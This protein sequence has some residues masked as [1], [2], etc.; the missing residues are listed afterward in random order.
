MPT[1]G[2]GLGEMPGVPED[3][4]QNHQKGRGKGDWKQRP[5]VQPRSEPRSGLVG[6]GGI[7]SS[8]GAMRRDELGRGGHPQE[9]HRGTEAV[10]PKW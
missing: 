2:P 3:D 4:P 9:R 8:G 5:R 7:L 10:W 6:G 1:V